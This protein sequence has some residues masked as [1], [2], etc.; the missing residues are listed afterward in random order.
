[1]ETNWAALIEHVHNTAT[2]CLR[3]VNRKQ[4]E[5][6]EVRSDEKL[7]DGKNYLYKVYLNDPNS[8]PKKDAFKNMRRTVRIFTKKLAIINMPNKFLCFISHH[9]IKPQSL[10]T[11]CLQLEG[12]RCTKVLYYWEF[13]STH[14]HSV[15]RSYILFFNFS[16]L[17][18]RCL[19]PKAVRP[20]FVL[21]FYELYCP[22]PDRNLRRRSYF[23]TPNRPFLYFPDITG[24]KQ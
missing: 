11:T 4:I 18:S 3:P 17:D 10:G 5:W 6:F 14:S 8:T 13:L 12:N 21:N 20:Y 15:L 7:L 24:P 22:K 1:M 19:F 16:F 2:E 23:P 9:S